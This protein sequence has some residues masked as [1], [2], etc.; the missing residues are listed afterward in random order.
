M[1]SFVRCM[2]WVSFDRISQISTRQQVRDAFL[3]IEQ[4][5]GVLTLLELYKLL[6]KN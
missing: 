6:L 3:M 4:C 5:Y 2:S 1:D